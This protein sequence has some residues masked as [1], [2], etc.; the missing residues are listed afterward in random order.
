M[1]ESPTPKGISEINEAEHFE[2][3]PELPISAHRNEILA[4][5]EK[6]Q[7]IIVCGDT[8]SGKTTQLPKIAME[9]GRGKNGRL[10]ACTQPR[11]LTAV[12]VAERVAQE[13]KTPVG[14]TIGYQHRFA[15]S[16]SENTRVKFMTDGVLLAET[17]HDPLLKA[18]D[19]IIIDEA[20]ERSLNI[21]FLLGILK[22]ILKHRSDLKLIVSSATLDTEKFSNFFSADI[23]Y[24]EPPEGEETNLPRDISSA[25]RTLPPDGDILVFLPGERDIREAADH[26]KKSPFHQYDDVIALMA[27]LPYPEQ[28]RAFR[29]SEKRRIVLSTNVAETSLTI[30][31]IRAVIDSGLAR[32]SR[33][34]HRTQVQ[35]L[36]I[37]PISQASAKQRTGRCGRVGPG[38]CIRLYSEAEFNSREKYTLPEVLRSSLAGVI[39]TMLDLRLGDI[40][41]FPFLDPP[42]PSMIREGLK[43]LLELGAIRHVE[44]NEN[45]TVE[46]I[47]SLT[48]TG[49][50]LA[51]IPIQP[52]LAKIMLTASELA[53]LPSALPVVASLSCDDPRRRPQDEKERADQAHAQFNVDGSDFL[54]TLKLWNWW[55]EQSNALSQNQL[56]KLAQKTFLAYSK[57]REWRDTVHQLTTLS[58]RLGLDIQ[59]DNGGSDSLHRALLSGLLTRIGHLDPETNEYRAA[60]A[61]KFALHPSSVL[62]KR[63]RAGKTNSGKTGKPEWVLA[64]E[65]VDTSR[66][67]ARNVAEIDVRW[68]EPLA[69]HLIKR[70]YR[71][72]EWDQQTGFA[73]VTEQVTLF[74]LVIVPARRRDLSSI[75]PKTARALMIE[76]GLVRGEITNPPPFIRENLSIIAEIS[77]RAERLRRPDLFDAQGIF[78]HFDSSIP[79]HVTSLPSLTKWLKLATPIERQAFKLDRR[80]FIEKADISSSDF[81]DFIRIGSSQIRLSY[82]HTPDNPETDGI[83]CTIRLK[84][85]HVLNLWNADWLVPGALPEKITFLLNSLPNSLRR[86]VSPIP[87]CVEII[88]PYLKPNE[89]KLHDAVSEVLKTKRGIFIPKNTWSDIK[90]PPHLQMRY[91]IKDDNGKILIQTRDLQVALSSI[92]GSKNTNG[93]EVVTSEKSADWS[94][95]DI[96]EK[97]E[98]KAASWTLTHYPALSDEKDGVTVRIFNTPEKAALSHSLGL[99]RLICLRLGKN[100]KGTFQ[101]KRLSFDAQLYLKAISYEPERIA[102]DLLWAAVRSTAVDSLSTIRTKEDFEERISK[103]RSEINAAKEN[104]AY[105]FAEA[106]GETAKISSRLEDGLLPTDIVDSIE[107]QLTWLVFPGFLKLASLER[108][109]HYL[110]YLKGINL[111]IDRA[112]ANPSSD[113]KKEERFFPYWERYRLALVSGK[114]SGKNRAQLDS[115]RWMIEEFRISVFAPELK[116]S[117]PVSEKRLDALWN[118]CFLI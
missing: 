75:D 34:V 1:Q 18:Y 115:Y 4:L 36:Q 24:K 78:K 106:I 32:I 22:R 70:S 60:H 7:T 42:K 31:G 12:S 53:A 55:E 77:N 99:T 82:R 40:E 16:V 80:K 87:E 37:E 33:Y 27:S 66:L 14:E 59:N 8:G 17:K 93:A 45:G 95:G 19:T 67:F 50:K 79:A 85:A 21:D 114:T 46:R 97:L 35:R 90:Y 113:R 117:F 29:T 11:R 71:T 38:I 104:M 76:H 102:E 10:I 2:Y 3:P 26:L 86:V 96:P 89:K 73:R 62:A 94:F 91:R 56:R 105:L 13:L 44:K 108:L 20:H 15:R 41:K 118:E 23:R 92:K 6:N 74:G 110:R 52:R 88:L 107:T 51:R 58:K 116:T 39:L 28:R 81:P 54:G 65:L 57:M 84:D 72:P 5:L 109:R 103:T 47:I 98:S 100:Q 68:I 83:T 30:P 49:K 25:I 101:T 64:S 48:D 61:L 112:R 111:R 43:E 63:R 69:K 9:L